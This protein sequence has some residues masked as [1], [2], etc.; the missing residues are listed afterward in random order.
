[1]VRRKGERTSR[2][3]ERHFPNIVELQ[4]PPNG[5]G[6]KLDLFY[7][8]RLDRGLQARHGRGQRRGEH[9]F[10]RWIA[11]MPKRSKQ[12]L[13]PRSLA[14]AGAHFKPHGQRL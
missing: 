3:N 4:V 12:F 6:A 13:A 7:R 5:F 2:A 14:K 11:P 1:M 9:D 8:F 10:V